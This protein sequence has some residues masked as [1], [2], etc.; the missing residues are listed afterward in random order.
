M[1]GYLAPKGDV[2]YFKFVAPAGHSKATVEATG[3]FAVQARVTDESK[4]PLGPSAPITP[5]K[6]YFVSVKAASEKSA[7]AKDP[8]TVTLRIE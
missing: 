5:G 1:R 6:T 7:N 8:Y 3:P 4:L 2:D